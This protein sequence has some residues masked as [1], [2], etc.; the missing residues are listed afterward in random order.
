MDI[1]TQ[2]AEIEKQFQK[3]FPRATPP[4]D[5][6]PKKASNSDLIKYGYLPHPPDTA[7][8]KLKDLWER[9][10]SLP[11]HIVDPQITVQ[12]SPFVGLALIAKPNVASPGWVG[13]TIPSPPSG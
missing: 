10:T 9:V 12:N 2:R 11:F 3:S 13:A 8:Q 5:F 4:T 7:P 6:D 1:S